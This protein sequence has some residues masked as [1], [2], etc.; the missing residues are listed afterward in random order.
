MT[1]AIPEC[2]TLRRASRGS[3]LALHYVHWRTITR[4]V[5]S[6]GNACPGQDSHEEHDVPRPRNRR[7]EFHDPAG[8]SLPSIAFRRRP[9]SP[10]ENCATRTFLGFFVISPPT[11]TSPFRPCVGSSRCNDTG[12]IPALFP[13][14]APRR[15][16][17][18]KRDRNWPLPRRHYAVLVG[19][20]TAPY[21]CIHTL[22]R[23]ELSA[24]A[25]PG[26]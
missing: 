13:S 7:I 16:R 4:S 15:I 3:P 23:T 18:R 14:G 11:S 10:V 12:I 22:P 20:F 6:I 25:A 1:F 19:P 21:T 26:E 5:E 9:D 17:S 2:A 8:L 24:D